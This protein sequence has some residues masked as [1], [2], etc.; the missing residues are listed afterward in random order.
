MSSVAPNGDVALVVEE[1][2]I[3]KRFVL[4]INFRFLERGERFQCV[5]M[6]NLERSREFLSALAFL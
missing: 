6:E 2:G 3:L 5:F 1:P 4:L